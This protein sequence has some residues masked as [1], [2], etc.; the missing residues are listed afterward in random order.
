MRQGIEPST[1]RKTLTLPM[2]VCARVIPQRYHAFARLGEATDSLDSYDAMRYHAMRCEVLGRSRLACMQHWQ[3]DC[4]RRLPP[5]DARAAGSDSTAVPG[6]YHAGASNVRTRR[7]AASADPLVHAGCRVSRGRFSA[8]RQ[9]GKR[10]YDLARQGKT[11]ERSAR[12]IRIEHLR[13]AMLDAS[14]FEIE[15][16]CGA[17]TYV[18]SLVVDIAAAMNAP[19]HMYRL[20]RLACGP[21]TIADTISYEA[22]SS[23]AAVIDAIECNRAKFDKYSRESAHLQPRERPNVNAPSES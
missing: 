21:F 13:G 10:L 12:P 8:L 5:R 1:R 19:A 3:G 20:E 17:G 6:R 7:T 4:S 16:E 14:T 22:C 23:A 18:R 2:C 9:Q 15:V 11:V